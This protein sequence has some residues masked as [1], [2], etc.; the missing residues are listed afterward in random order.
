[1]TDPDRPEDLLSDPDRG[2]LVGVE[3]ISAEGGRAGTESVRAPAAQG[4]G[5]EVA[6]PDPIPDA[7]P[8]PD[9]QDAPFD[10][11]EDDVEIRAV[12]VDM[13]G[14]I[15]DLG[16][17]RGLPWG[18]LDRRG[19][20]ALLERIREEDGARGP[21]G[22]V[23]E[24]DL[25]RLL[26]EPWRRG[27]A[28]RR[29]LGREERWGP[30]LAR[31]ARRVGVRVPRGSL[32][33]AWARP[34]LDG[35]QPLSGAEEVLA[36]LTAA[37]L[38]L[39]LVSNVPLPGSFYRRVLGR[40]ALAPYFQTLLFSYDQRARKPGPIMLQRALDRLG[41]EPDE[42]VMV[43]DRRSTD[44]R[45]GRAAGVRTVWVESPD[46]DGPEPDAVIGSIVELPEL[47]GL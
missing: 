14:V 15:L 27:Y 17:A 36:R 31:L 16:E 43:G 11:P 32:L 6:G 4:V 7:D 28:R 42:A 1:M 37:D 5:A 22:P 24:N 20:E 47:L 10:D 21:E 25:D 29:K 45:A 19:R 33:E 12:L 39:A 26:F 9:P 18:E 23:T 40:Q 44:V 30:H 38:K 2:G 35:L 13:G 34:Y 46:A 8:D 3:E 41:V